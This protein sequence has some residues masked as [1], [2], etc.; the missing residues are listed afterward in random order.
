MFL[1]VLLWDVEAFSTGKTWHELW[2]M[3]NLYPEANILA[4]SEHMLGEAAIFAPIY[5]LTGEAIL[6]FNFMLALVFVLDFLCAY[7]VARRLLRSPIPALSSAVLFTFG[8]YRL[9][10]IVHLQLLVHFPTP[11]LFLAA[12]RMAERPGWRWPLLAGLCL[13]GQFYLGMSLGYFAAVMLGLML[14]T[15]AAYAPALFIDFHFLGRLGLAGFVTGLLLLPLAGP[16]HEAAE[17]WGCWEWGGPIMA[18]VPGWHNFFSPILDGDRTPQSMAVGAERATYWGYLPWILFAAGVAAMIQQGRRGV[19]SVPFWAVSCMALVLAI[20]CLCVNHFGSYEFLFRWLPGF[21]GLR[22]PGRLALLALWPCSLLGGWGLAWIGKVLLPW[23]PRRRA[24]LSLGVVI[25]VFLEN[26]HRLDVWQQHWS[27]VRCPREEFYAK[28]VRELPPGAVATLPFTGD[29]GEPY[30]VAGAIAA[31]WRPTLSVYT[32]RVPSWLPTLRARACSL[33]NP[34]QAAA[35]MGEMHLRGIRFVILDRALASSAQI[36]CWRQARTSDSRTWGES[37]YE[38]EQNLILD[39]GAIRAEACL[40]VDWASAT[41]KPNEVCRGRGNAGDGYFTGP[42]AVTFEPTM[43]LRPGR[44]EATFELQADRATEGV[45]EVT[46]IFLDS[47][48]PPQPDWR[49]PPVTLAR[50]PL[51]GENRTLTFTVPEEKGPEPIFQFRIVHK[52]NGSLRVHRVRIT[53]VE[54]SMAALGEKPGG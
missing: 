9:Y 43:P 18:F 11:L 5:W 16:Y 20:G 19:R 37:I 17:R 38:D 51:Q 47:R 34:E 10:Q 39:M 54:Q 28:V 52:G 27:D 35:L 33:S 22:V 1:N 13:A 14:L 50:A 31:G 21:N 42:G 45:C 6:S 40:P 2:Q 4:T 48:D 49:R 25:L 30:D 12:I 15:L 3:P 8:S 26:Y 41:A 23:T 36:R 44:Y 32:S 46:R 29:A 53:P 24:V 7:L